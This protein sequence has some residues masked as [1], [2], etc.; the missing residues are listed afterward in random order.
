M[1]KNIWIDTDPGI[2]D[3]IAI[4]A[5]F[6]ASDRLNLCGISAVA[7]NQTV[8]MVARNAMWLTELLGYPECPVIQGA[9]RPLIRTHQPAGHIHGEQGLG[10]IIPG[11]CRRKLTS[12]QGALAI[13]QLIRALPDNEKITMVTIAP[14]TNIA[15][16]VRSFPE[17]CSR[18][19]KIVCMGGSTVGG[20]VTPAAEF[21]IWAD[22]EA[23]EIVFQSGIPIV[24]CGLDVTMK[25][26]LNGDDIDCLERG[27]KV[28]QQ[29]AGMLRFY[30][31]SVAYRD[32]G[33]VAMHDATTIMY[34]LYEDLFS[35]EHHAMH[36]SCTEDTCR[37]MTM[38]W[39][40]AYS[41]S[42]RD[43]KKNV[44]VVKDTDPERFRKEL[45]ALLMSLPSSPEPASLAH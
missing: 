11:A 31:E 18:I 2:D 21:N 15:L 39:D 3:A 20:N 9:D 23:A 45:M 44:Y 38:I 37:G 27:G 35:G 36:V 12:D 5:A 33:A 22:P 29:L 13:Y 17:I 41:Y 6:A 42:T 24:M 28:Q 1:R 32:L 16:L 19:E 43:A 25:C 14:L 30:L 4:A 40:S 8:G 10:Y 7:G 34:L 26:L